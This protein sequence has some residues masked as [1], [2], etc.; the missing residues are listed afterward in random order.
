MRED[1]IDWFNLFFL[2]LS[3]I[4]ILT[5]SSSFPFTFLFSIFYQTQIIYWLKIINL[6]IK[7]S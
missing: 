1:T 2:S 4:N 3:L 6:L 7:F 5:Y